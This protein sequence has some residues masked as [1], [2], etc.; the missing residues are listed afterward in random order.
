VLAKLYKFF[1]IAF[2]FTLTVDFLILHRNSLNSMF[3]WID[4]IISF[5]DNDLNDDLEAV[6]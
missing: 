6:K 2:A 3:T 1:C 4:E 5:L